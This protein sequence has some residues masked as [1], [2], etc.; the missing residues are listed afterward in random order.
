MRTRCDGCCRRKPRSRSSR[1]PRACRGWLPCAAPGPPAGTATIPIGCRIDL[2]A[3]T[4]A[5]PSCGPDSLGS[6]A[7]WLGGDT[8][9]GRASGRSSVPRPR[10]RRTRP[11]PGG[12]RDEPR[13]GVHVGKRARRVQ[14]DLHVRALLHPAHI[15]LGPDQRTPGTPPPQ[16]RVPVAGAEQRVS[17]SRRSCHRPGHIGEAHRLEVR[18]PVQ[19]CRFPPRRLRADPPVHR[20]GQLG[21]EQLRH[22][23][24]D[25]HD[26]DRSIVDPALPLPRGLDEQRHRE[27]ILKRPCGRDPVRL[28]GPERDP[29]VRR[30]H[31]QRPVVDPDLL[32]VRQQPSE[33]GVHGTDLQEMSL[34]DLSDVL[35]IL[36]VSFLVEALSRQPRHPSSRP[37][38]P[39][40]RQVLEVLVRQHQVQVVQ[41]RVR[42]GLH[43]FDEAQ[44]GLPAARPP[45]GRA[46]PRVLELLPSPRERF[47]L[48]REARPP[49]GDRRQPIAQI[50]AQDQVEVHDGQIRQHPGQALQG[51]PVLVPYAQP[52][53]TEL[54][55]DARGVHLV[56][57]REQGEQ[58]VRV[59]NR[60]REPVGPR[61]PAGQDGR[62]RVVGR[63]RDRRRP[64]VPRGVAD[65]RREVRVSPGVDPL[66]PV[67]QRRGRKLVEDHEDDRGRPRDRLRLA[68][69]HLSVVHQQRRDRRRGDEQSGEDDHPRRQQGEEEPD[70]AETCVEHRDP[71]SEHERRGHERDARHGLHRPQRGQHG[72]RD[73]YRQDGLV[74]PVSRARTDE[75]REPPGGD[76][77][78]RDRPA[79]GHHQPQDLRPPGVLEDEELGL[80]PQQVV[81]RLGH[82]EARHHPDMQAPG[83]WTFP[84]GR[85]LAARSASVLRPHAFSFAQGLVGSAPPMP[86][87][88]PRGRRRP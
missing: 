88:C 51:A 46:P 67:H 43:P 22:D 5:D 56:G 20:P 64:P 70:R 15:D 48:F 24:Q 52:L 59:I 58:A 72:Q 8:A 29:V 39:P 82:R 49:V 47:H 16:A 77:D 37:V 33:P 50:G 71:R 44:P 30:Q 2:P 25:V 35:R 28:T 79:Q 34:V 62:H 32:Q 7:D 78:E 61:V 81:Q 85:G 12:R 45:E 55:Q 65:Q 86:A 84:P 10:P 69:R 3:P 66:L 80:V 75:T 14:P 11:A 60:V 31:N 40:R 21:P 73:P 87:T 23:G 13:R 17:P 18:P 9:W 26:L 38:P 68:L 42:H 4:R 57:A 63:L 1:V 27:D 74:D 6:G 83:P 41:R 53:R 19:P 36:R 76:Q 54:G